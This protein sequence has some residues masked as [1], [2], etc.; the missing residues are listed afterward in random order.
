MLPDEYIEW[1]EVPALP[2]SYLELVSW[3]EKQMILEFNLKSIKED[4]AR[5][6][7]D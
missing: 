3:L 2:D 7:S 6:K 4:P 1:L 5:M